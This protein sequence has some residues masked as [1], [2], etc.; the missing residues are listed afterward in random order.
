MLAKASPRPRRAIAIHYM[1]GEARFVAGGQHVMKQFVELEDGIDGL[2][3]ISD[4][5]WTRR[6][7]HPS[8]ILKKGE[9]VEV[10]VLNID[11]GERRISLGLKQTQENPWPTIESKYPAGTEVEGK[12]VR[13]IDRGVVV[14]LGEDLE[15]FVSAV[16]EQ[17]EASFRD[18]P[19][20]A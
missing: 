3:H 12:V 11:K 9:K 14:D 17:A 15:G 1:T 4:M 7:G 6:V 2:V 8:E 18:W 13:V 19:L 16:M 5:S 10:K 20:A